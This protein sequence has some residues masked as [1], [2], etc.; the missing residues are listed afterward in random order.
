M[1]SNEAIIWIIAAFVILGIAL[2]NIGETQSEPRTM[3][4]LYQ[5]VYEGEVSEERG[6]VH[7]GFA[8][9]KVDGLWR[10]RVAI[11]G[12]TYNLE[13]HYSPHEVQGIPVEGEVGRS[14][15]NKIM[16]FTFDP[17]STQKGHIGV[18]GTELVS[19][20]HKVFKREVIPTCTYN[21]TGCEDRPITTCDSTNLPVF[22][23]K[24][25]NE[26]K[27][28]IDENCMTFQ[29]HKKEMIRAVDRML[30]EWYHIL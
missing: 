6:F 10:T 1:K 17:N 14:F 21:A 24:A 29:G 25:A 18:A 22:Y 3:D 15:F 7:N 23:F 19:S 20:V 9:A 30:Y 16:Y 12:T 13:F 8:F 2:F 28:T 5:A 11:N 27:V 4:E 26:T